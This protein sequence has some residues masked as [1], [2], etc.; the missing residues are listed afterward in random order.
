[1]SSGMF[2]DEVRKLMELEERMREVLEGELGIPVQVKL[3]EPRSIH[4]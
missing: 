2:V 1:M 3:V 4:A